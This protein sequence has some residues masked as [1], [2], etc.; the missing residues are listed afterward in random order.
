[1]CQNYEKRV[2]DFILEMSNPSTKI[3]IKDVTERVDNPKVDLIKT[4]EIQKP[5]IFKGYTCELDRIKDT[6]RNNQY[7]YNLPDYDKIIK[8]KNINSH[9]NCNTNRSVTKLK[10]DLSKI[11][12]NTLL[13]EDETIKKS[14]GLSVARDKQYQ[15]MLKNDLILQPQMRFKPR[16]DLERVYDA[17]NGYRYGENEKQI[18]ERQLR[19]INLLN[20]KTPYELYKNKADHKRN[21]NNKNFNLLSKTGNS[22][23]FSE[24]KDRKN[25]NDT[26][27]SHQKL[28]FTPLKTTTTEN[29]KPWEKRFD[30]NHEAQKLLKPYHYKLHFQAAKEIA[31][32]T[33]NNISFHMNKKTNGTESSC[34]LLPNINPGNY[35]DKK[36]SPRNSK[37]FKEKE[38]NFN[39]ENET[40][41]CENVYKNNENPLNIKEKLKPTKEAMKI[42]KN[43]AFEEKNENNNEPNKEI[44]YIKVS[45]E[46]KNED[47]DVVVGNEIINKKKNFDLL[48]NKVLENCNVWNKKSMF[49]DTTLKKGTGKTMITQGMTVNEFE[50]KYGLEEN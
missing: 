39:D 24:K 47:D 3:E 1:M 36:T 7:L 40:E 19:S 15:Y 28:Y 18:I 33:R 29:I 2:K 16:T 45:V 17:L 25:E 48:T 44:E 30:L 31:S 42:L 9:S 35:F 49:N 20:Y 21:K 34:F 22:I 12:I 50:K 4:K 43:M 38:I 26:K 6:V 5:F 23:D 41:N 27:T 13:N 8:K 11:N 46:Q 10:L 32:N 14:R 37:E